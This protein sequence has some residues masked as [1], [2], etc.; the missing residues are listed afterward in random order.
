MKKTYGKLASGTHLYYGF[1]V[2]EPKYIK[3]REETG[4]DDTSTWST[5][6]LIVMFSI[7]RIEHYL[8]FI[9]SSELLGETNEFVE[10][11]KKILKGLKLFV[12]NK[13]D[14][15]WSEK[16]AKKV[17]YALKHFGKLLPKLWT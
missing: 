7:D 17:E 10:E 4:L 2:D 16:D 1:R 6:D 9:K 14:R 15:V 11:V 13:G 5:G 8:S 12:R 3:Q